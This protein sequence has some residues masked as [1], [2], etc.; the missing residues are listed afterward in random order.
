MQGDAKAKVEFSLQ[1]EKSPVFEVLEQ[2]N[3]LQYQIKSLRIS[4]QA[5]NLL[6]NTNNFEEKNVGKLKEPADPCKLKHL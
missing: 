3:V 2:V 6:E 5:Q 1:S 4:E